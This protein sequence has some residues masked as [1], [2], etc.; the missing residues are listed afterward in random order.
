[1]D[2]SGLIFNLQRFCTDDGDGIRTTVFFKG[3]PLHCLWCHN[4]ESQ[5]P[6]HEICFDSDACILCGACAAA[7]PQGCHTGNVADARAFARESC[8]RCGLCADVCPTGALSVI[9]KHQTVREILAEAKKDVD[10]YGKDGGITLSGGEPLAQPQLAIALAKEAKRQGLNVCVETSGFCA[11]ET[12]EAIVPFVD[13]F[14]FDYKCAPADYPALVGAPFSV[15]EKS[16]AFLAA[17]ARRTVLRCP[18]VPECI[19]EDHFESIALL[20]RRYRIAEAQLLP[21]HRLGIG[22]CKRLGR[23]EQRAFTEPSK[24]ELF[25]IAYALS[26]KHGLRI[27]VK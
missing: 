5:S 9:G 3:C 7:C 16:L 21:Y 6:T 1:M 10:F 22:K 19:R 20:M 12:L 17:N 23:P 27:T 26:E 14:L 24:N 13:C 8:E 4:P 2:T 15:I 11:A 18:I 25:S